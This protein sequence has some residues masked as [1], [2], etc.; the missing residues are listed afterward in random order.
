MAAMLGHSDFVLFSRGPPTPQYWGVRIGVAELLVT[1]LLV[2]V[3]SEGDDPLPVV[4]RAGGLA[5][6]LRL[7]HLV[8]EVGR[9]GPGPTPGTGTGLVIVLLASSALFSQVTA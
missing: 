9:A 6:W 4:G 5:G 1:E 8:R 3:R 2:A 7:R